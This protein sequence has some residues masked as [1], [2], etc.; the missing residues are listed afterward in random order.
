MKNSNLEK[1][2]EHLNALFIGLIAVGL[3]ALFFIQIIFILSFSLFI[4][5]GWVILCVI[6]YLFANHLKAKNS[7]EFDFYKVAE[8][9][10]R[11]ERR[12]KQNIEERVAIYIDEDGLDP[13]IIFDEA[14]SGVACLLKLSGIA[15]N[16]KLQDY[17]SELYVLSEQQGQPIA[18]QTLMEVHYKGE[19]GYYRLTNDGETESIDFAFPENSDLLYE[20]VCI[21]I[22]RLVSDFRSL[23][24]TKVNVTNYQAMVKFYHYVERLSAPE[25]R[26]VEYLSYCEGTLKVCNTSYVELY[27]CTL[28]STLTSW[29]NQD[30]LIRT[31][32]VDIDVAENSVLQLMDIEL[33]YPESRLVDIQIVK[34]AELQ[35]GVKLYLTFAELVDSELSGNVTGLSLLMKDNSIGI[36]R[37]EESQEVL[38][39][40][41][42]YFKQKSYPLFE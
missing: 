39:S 24:V 17:L 30:G 27:D 6:L 23:S 35:K 15:L 36:K 11:Q 9:L 14:K 32:N 31:D 33:P 40:V 25:N 26:C 42:D 5:L 38:I 34:L 18:G 13:Q 8:P 28:Q 12:K 19:S 41:A 10:G 2:A 22:K 7:N 20:Q 16:H 29:I 3:T 21:A 37:D 1:V 4:Y